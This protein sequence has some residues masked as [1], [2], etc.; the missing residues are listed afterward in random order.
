LTLSISSSHERMRATLQL[1]ALALLCIWGAWCDD[2][3]SPVPPLA[4][5]DPAHHAPTANVTRVGGATRSVGGADRETR[6][7]GVTST[8]VMHASSMFYVSLKNNEDWNQLSEFRS[9]MTKKVDLGSGLSPS[10][11]LSFKATHGGAARAAVLGNAPAPLYHVKGSPTG[12]RDFALCHVPNAMGQRWEL[13]VWESQGGLQELAAA[14]EEGRKPKRGLGK[15]S[16]MQSLCLGTA[17]RSRW[18]W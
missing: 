17:R 1:L 13:L 4:A 3:P 12:A 6:H 10:Q 5:T 2:E 9:C 18:R 14:K 16:E 8:P 11:L 7:P 15:V